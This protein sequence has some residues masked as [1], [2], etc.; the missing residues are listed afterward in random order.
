M[1]H[2]QAAG[3]VHGPGH[4]GRSEVGDQEPVADV[5]I[6]EE[7][8]PIDRVVAA[9]MYL[10]A[11]PEDKAESCLIAKRHRQSHPHIAYER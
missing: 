4:E 10:K 11:A 3:D 1:K 9:D 2:G 6:L 5:G 7:L 8:D